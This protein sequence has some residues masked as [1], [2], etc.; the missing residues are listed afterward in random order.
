MKKMIIIGLLMIFCSS[1]VLPNKAM[2]DDGA[3]QGAV[4]GAAI[5]LVI[6]LIA[7]AVTHGKQ[8]PEKLDKEKEAEGKIARRPIFA[9]NNLTS[10]VSPFGDE[11]KRQPVAGSAFTIRF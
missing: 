4:I 10:E 6:A 8:S 5:G 1:F 9:S 7:V 2:A 3:G 11:Y